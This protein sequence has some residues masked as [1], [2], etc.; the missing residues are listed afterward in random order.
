MQD[1]PHRYS[2]A[3]LAKPEG[4]VTLQSARL[5]ALASA[6]PA[7]FGGPGDRWSPETLLVAAVADCF[8]LS[9][10][11][12]A[13]AAKLP[14]LSLRCEADGTLD[15]VERVTQFTAFRVSATLRVPPGT[16][17]AQARKSLERAEQICLITNSLKAASQLETV[18]EIAPA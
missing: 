2:V 17:E 18:I 6:P 16:D 14:W 15:R 4:E 12:V 3:S 11:A 5:P 10:R 13:R 8:I 7:E 1:L 9:F